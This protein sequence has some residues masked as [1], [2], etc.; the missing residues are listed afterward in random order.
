MQF[1]ALSLLASLAPLPAAAFGDL[2]CITIS[3]CGN[4][5]CMP[6]TTPFGVTFDWANDSVM[7]TVEDNDHVL[8][9]VATDETTDGL[10]SVIEYGDME[11]TNRLLRIEANGA[12]ITAYYTFRSPRVTTWE[13][14]CDLRQAA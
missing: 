5:G 2:D 8:P 10:G 3:S 9:W 1:K 11:D 12:T 6:E 13:A 7:V 4:S 14:T